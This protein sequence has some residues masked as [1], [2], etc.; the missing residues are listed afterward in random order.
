MNPITIEHGVI[1]KGRLLGQSNAL[2]P[3]GFDHEQTLIDS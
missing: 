1:L 2:D 3:S